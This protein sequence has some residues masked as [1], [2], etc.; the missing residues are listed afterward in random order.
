MQDNKMLYR[1]NK[2]IKLNSDEYLLPR[3]EFPRLSSSIYGR[4]R[5]LQRIGD[6][7]QFSNFGM[8][9][10]CNRWITTNNYCEPMQYE[11]TGCCKAEDLFTID[12]LLDA[13]IKIM[14]TMSYNLQNHVSC[15]IE[16]PINRVFNVCNFLKRSTTKWYY[17]TNV[18]LVSARNPERNQLHFNLKISKKVLTEFGIT[19]AKWNYVTA[20]AHECTDIVLPDHLYDDFV[21]EKYKE[22]ID[23]I[24][25]KIDK[26]LLPYKIVQLECHSVKARKRTEL[27]SESETGSDSDSN[28]DSDSDSLN[29]RATEL[30]A[31]ARGGPDSGCVC[32]LDKG[33]EKDIIIRDRLTKAIDKIH[34]ELHNNTGTR[35]THEQFVLALKMFPDIAE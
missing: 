2:N 15:V 34:A 32:K 27:D 25:H 5:S 12:T 14:F 22:A 24:T 10:Q 1:R 23:L 9:I 29:T 13:M 20:M 3:C 8:F 21:R 17:V 19:T 4:D 33:T 31:N 7:L 18:K 28:S 35:L 16:F 26:H 6:M 30:N 11:N